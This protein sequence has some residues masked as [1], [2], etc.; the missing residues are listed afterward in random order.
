VHMAAGTGKGGGSIIHM[1]A[2][3]AGADSAVAAADQTSKA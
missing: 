3:G 1:A 2:D